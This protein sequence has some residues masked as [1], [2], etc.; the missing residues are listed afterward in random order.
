M[1]AYSFMIILSFPLIFL[2]HSA[3]PMEKEEVIKNLREIQEKTEDFSADLLQEKKLSLF[4]EKIVSKGKIQFKKP[5][6]FSI[7]F[8]H[9]ESI[10]IVF[11]GKTL[12]LY[13]KEEKVA[14][15][16]SLHSNP[17]IEKVLL[18][19][20]DPFQEKL[21]DWEIMEDRP[22]FLVIEIIPKV[23]ESPFAKTRLRISKKDWRVIGMEMIEKNGDMTAIHYSN[24]KVNQ[25]LQD[26]DFE[27]R[28]PKDVK[29]TKIK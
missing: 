12:L 14:E 22:S 4:K 5:D 29:V 2:I 10:L 17:M 3:L 1:K 8:F 13:Y 27:I 19:S 11:N 15:Y 28:L 25:G 18:F 26:A 24:I 7:E 20:K 9:P 6:K 16:F 21:T 23:R